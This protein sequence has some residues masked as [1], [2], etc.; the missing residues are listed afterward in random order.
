ME[1]GIRAHPDMNAWKCIKSMFM[2]WH[3]EFTTIWLNIAFAV[4][5]WVNIY[6]I[7]IKDNWYG[8]KQEE[9]YSYMLILTLT[10][11]VSL[12]VTTCF[13]IFYP[14]S[15][16]TLKALEYFDFIGKII[17][18]GVVTSILLVAEMAP[19]P[20][21]FGD[22]TLLEIM[23]GIVAIFFVTMTALSLFGKQM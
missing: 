10:I 7:G 19:Y 2:V 8:Y 17:L 14:I 11:A 1:L 22:L 21:Q 4:Y 15:E 6:L 9:Y 20:I 12:T 18:I 3:C 16:G 13:I 5:F 23:E